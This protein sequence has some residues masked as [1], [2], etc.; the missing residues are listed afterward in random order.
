MHGRTDAQ[1]VR[2]CRCRWKFIPPI[3]R[4]TR[5]NRLTQ[6][7]VTNV[8]GVTIVIGVIGVTIVKLLLLA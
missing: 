5:F 4:L 7:T 8:I 6:L 3:N 1:I 2:L